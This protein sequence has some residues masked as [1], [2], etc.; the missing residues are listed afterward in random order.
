MNQSKFAADDAGL[1]SD[2]RRLADLL[3]QTLVRQEGPDLLELVEAVR[4]SVR[5][6]S[7]EEVLANI[8]DEESVQLAR[9]FSTYFNL[10]NVAEQIHRA[11]VLSHSRATGGSWLVRAV[12]RIEEALSQQTPGH[13]LTKEEITHWVSEMSV[14]P[15]FTA[16]P[17]E[18][19]RRSILKKLGAIADLL[20]QPENPSQQDRLAENIDLLW[21]TD[22]LRLGQPEPLDEALNAL[23]YLDD[24]FTQTVPEVLND[25]AK[26]LSRIGVVVPV[27]A[28]PLSFG[29]WIGGDRDGNPN[30]TADVTTK[31]MVLQVGH[32]IRVTIA[33]MNELRQMLS[34][35]TNIVG[36]TP[37][38]TASVEKDFKH[39]P[40]FEPRFLRLNAEEPYRLKATAIVHRLAFTRDRH[41]IGG[42]HVANRDYE[43]TRELLADL[44][45]MRDS[46]LAHRGELIATG[47]LERTIRTVAAF[48]ITHATMDIREHSDAHHNLLNQVL[49]VDGYLSKSH[50]EKF[51]LLTALLAE[52]STF[53]TSKLD[54]SGKR[55]FDTFVAINDLI[56]R[57][58]PESIETYIVSM[59]KGADDLIAP[60]VI[61]QQAGLVSLKEK[62]ARIGFAPL[63]ET[64]TELRSSGEILDKLLSN[65]TYRQLV[66]LRGDKQE[67]MLGYSDSNKDAGI[68]TSQWEIH[69]A[70]RSL[71]DV[72]KKHGVKLCLFHGRGGSVGRGGGPTY[73]ALIALPWGSVDGAIKMTEQGEVIS[74]KY[75]LASLARENIELTLAASLEAIVLNRGPR[76]SKEELT[77]WGD[78]MQ[79]ISDESFKQYRSLIQQPDLPAYFYASTPVEQL[80]EMFLG[81]RPSRRPDA[82]G[83]LDSLRAIPWVFGWTQS[84][85]I[86]PGWFGVGTGLKAA[87]EAGQ[88]K[89]LRKMLKEWHFFTT[90]I[91][92]VEMTL[93]KTDLDLAQRYVEALVPKELHHFLDEIKEE[94]DLTVSEILRLTGEKTL[95]GD[96]E[97]LARTLQVRDAYLS[98]IHLLQINLLKRVRETDTSV[99]P[100]LR[101]AL[102]LTINGVA[103]GLRNTG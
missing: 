90:F 73:D 75:A 4:K 6:G 86:V 74:D 10:A 50:E 23:Y 2:V 19:A 102:L 29:N 7:G 98:P 83:G 44:V 39:I 53:D 96:Q 8:T 97:I 58:G 67:V 77:A 99:D 14:R 66:S 64:V 13:Q 87:R 16:H 52:N 78:C 55:V 28:R 49:G 51:D 93:A 103:A 76:Q 25:F 79:L 43:N 57:F 18:A 22:E 32:S 12:D 101:R 9:A 3:G 91:S 34:V 37:E 69:R 33:A 89:L 80:G 46:L 56:D 30:I 59:T 48:G 38:L 70:Q 35:S 26:E 95:L 84:R 1:R 17:T 5:K 21:Q 20:D 11:R 60:I 61:A 92:N 45:L 27:T 63:L 41:A 15:V 40:E 36:A 81:S 71:R 100:V 62:K 47:L 82:S 65:P 72:A 94:F 54:A 31:A 85:Q 68:A 88:S 24:L 42:P